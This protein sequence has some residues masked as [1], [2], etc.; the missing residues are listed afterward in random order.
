MWLHAHFSPSPPYTHTHKHT[1]THTHSLT[2]EL[3]QRRLEAAAKVFEDSMA[4]LRD[5]RSR[6][7]EVLGVGCRVQG[8]GMA[9]KWPL[10]VI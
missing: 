5:N 7:V 9:L 4:L 1:L 3:G 2:T 10:S 6:I 8:L